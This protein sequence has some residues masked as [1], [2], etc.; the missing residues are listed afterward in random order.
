M[1]SVEVTIIRNNKR[2]NAKLV[3]DTKKL[4]IDLIMEN[5]FSKVYTG[6][7]FYDCLSHIRADHRDITFLCKGAKINVHPSS[8]SS[9]MSLGIKAYELTLGKAPSLSDVVSIFDY[10]E[11]NLTND[12]EIQKGF[13]R[14]WL[15]TDNTEE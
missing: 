4:T 3:C 13:Y 7:D 15:E 12:P 14:L 11:N 8:M 10:E 1:D 9:Q 5:G 2:Q 6:S